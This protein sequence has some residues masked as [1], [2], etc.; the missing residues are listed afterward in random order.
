MFQT[1]LI[2]SIISFVILISGCNRTESKTLANLQSSTDTSSQEAVMPKDNKSSSNE[3]K[4]YILVINNST[5]FGFINNN[6]FTKESNLNNKNALSY[7]G[8]NEIFKFYDITG[9]LGNGTNP[10]YT[11]PE[12]IVQ[13]ATD[14][15][16]MNLNIPN[17][18]G[19]ANKGSSFRNLGI[20]CN[21]EPLPRKVV[22]QS[23]ALPVYQEAIKN[24]LIQ[25]GF[26]TSSVDIKKVLSFDMDGNGVNET[27]IIASNHEPKTNGLGNG[28]NVYSIVLLIIN[29]QDSV[30]NIIL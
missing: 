19:K 24:I 11:L 25:K 4:P 10:K 18:N 29:D 6:T 27:I 30:K 14:E 8:G 9:Y 28:D 13:G 21:W 16:V 20:Y 5:V 1:L 15:I 3:K 22:E 26:K 23:N 7:I 2:C 17:Q 12:E